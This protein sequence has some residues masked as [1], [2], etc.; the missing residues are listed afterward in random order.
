MDIGYF[1]EFIILCKCKN[2]TIAANEL[3]ITQS[4]LS[5]HMKAI[6]E[7]LGGVALFDRTSRRFTLTEFGRYFLE[8]AQKIDALNV[9]LINEAA[10]YQSIK[11]KEIMLLGIDTMVDYSVGRSII[12]WNADVSHVPV[13]IEFYNEH[14]M[15][16]ILLNR[17]ADLAILREPYYKNSEL[18]KN[19]IIRDRIGAIVPVDHPSNEDGTISIEQLEND[20]FIRRGENSAMQ[21]LT[22][23]LFRNAGITPK[24]L[25]GVIRSNVYTLSTM[26][27]DGD[28]V[29]FYA[30]TPAMRGVSTANQKVKFCIL[31]PEEYMNFCLVYHKNV[32]KRKEVKGFIN[33]ILENSKMNSN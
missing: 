7:E 1:R 3:Y 6:E 18:E 30:E 29:V 14:L 33:Y 16:N 24:F 10:K 5:K 9:E 4:S 20:I 2:F 19:I 26:V 21:Q 13:N 27:A 23:R 32:L 17:A 8:Q 25:R 22:E 28:G 11:T 31:K 12:E 15:C